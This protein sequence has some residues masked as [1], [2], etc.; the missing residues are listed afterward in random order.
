MNKKTYT[1]DQIKNLSKNKNIAHCGSTKIRYSKAFKQ[2][3]IKQY[4]KGLSAIEIF[5]NAVF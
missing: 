1:H 4:N 5:Q 2:A 3:A